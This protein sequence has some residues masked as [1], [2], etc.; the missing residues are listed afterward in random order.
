MSASEYFITIWFII[1]TILFIYYIDLVN[2]R[3][4][5]GLYL[6]LKEFNIGMLTPFLHFFLQENDLNMF[7]IKIIWF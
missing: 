3:F 6:V 2:H 4:I 5:L 1:F 7:D